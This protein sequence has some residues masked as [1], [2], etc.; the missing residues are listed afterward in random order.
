M[1]TGLRLDSISVCDEAARNDDTDLHVVKASVSDPAAFVYTTELVLKQVKDTLIKAETTDSPLIHPVTVGKLR[2]AG[3]RMKKCNQPPMKKGQRNE[4]A[5][6]KDVAEE[7]ASPPSAAIDKDMKTERKAAPKGESESEEETREEDEKE[8]KAE[9]TFKEEEDKEEEE[10]EKES[11]GEGKE[12]KAGEETDLKEILAVLR[13][14][15][16][17][18]K[19]VH[20]EV[21]AI[22]HEGRIAEPPKDGKKVVVKTT[23]PKGA[24]HAVQKAQMEQDFQKALDTALALRDKKIEDLEKALKD[25]S[26]KLEAYA[27][28]TIQKSG[29]YLLTTDNEGKPILGNAGAIAAQ[30]QGSVN[31]S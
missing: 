12:K 29:F 19:K 26:D 13:K 6:E 25:T 15:V 23:P 7:K 3:D 8:E 28:E 10:D 4:E 5:E 20:E 14:L 30:T 27:N 31:K 9:E 22:D 11:G 21:K 24:D 17:S 18:D 1:T 16:A 2:T